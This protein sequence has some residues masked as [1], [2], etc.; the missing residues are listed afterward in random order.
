MDKD[1]MIQNKYMPKHIKQHKIHLHPIFLTIV[2]EQTNTHV[3]ISPV[4]HKHSIGPCLL[5][6]RAVE[7]IHP[8]TQSTNTVIVL[9][10]AELRRQVELVVKYCDAQTAGCMF[11]FT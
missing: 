1:K 4:R 11:S 3:I 6:V 5:P 10:P 2:R 8:I 7:R 9:T